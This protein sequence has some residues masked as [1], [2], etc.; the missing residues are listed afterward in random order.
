MITEIGAVLTM[1]EVRLLRD[2]LAPSTREDVKR[3]Q[4]A[5]I[6]EIYGALKNKCQEEG[7]Q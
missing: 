4:D 1:D 6:L 3:L 7:G 5:G 2:F